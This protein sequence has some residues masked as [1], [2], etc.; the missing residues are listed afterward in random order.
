[1]NKKMIFYTFVP[2]DESKLNRAYNVRIFYLRKTFEKMG[3]K[4]Y[5]ID[6]FY[7]NRK[8]KVL[9]LWKIIQNGLNIDFVYGELPTLPFLLTSK[10]RLPKII[11]NIDIKFMQYLK[12]RN[13]KIG[14]FLG[15]L[16]NYTNVLDNFILKKIIYMIFFNFSIMVLNSIIDF[17]F[18]PTERF[19]EIISY[20]YKIK[21]DKVIELS[22]GIFLDG[23]SRNDFNINLDNI[24]LLYIGGGYDN[25]ELLKAFNYLLQKNI[26]DIFLYFVSRFNE[27]TKSQKTKYILNLLN[28]LNSKNVYMFDGINLKQLLKEFSNNIHVGSLFYRTYKVKGTGLKNYDGKDYLCIT[29]PTK[30]VEYLGIYLPVITYS[31]TYV[32]KIIKENDIGW[33]IDYDYKELFKLLIY[34]RN[35]KEEI[36]KKRRNI[37]KIINNFSWENVVKKILSKLAK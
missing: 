3:F 34:L 18:V 37:E 30:F 8:K 17:F 16:Y 24:G 4:V 31:D 1:M 9:E 22:P 15:D 23:D 11:R 21:K 20:S 19:S 27:Y 32:S 12:E 13:I 5:F 26:N 35:N 28:Y 14:L 2:F 10:F 25:I 7:E 33:I 6:G 36:I 29:F